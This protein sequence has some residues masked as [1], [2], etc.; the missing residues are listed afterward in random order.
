S[1]AATRH[2]RGLE[3]GP[4]GRRQAKREVWPHSLR[5]AS[6]RPLGGHQCPGV[7]AARPPAFRAAARLASKRG[8]KSAPEAISANKV[9]PTAL[10]VAASATLAGLCCWV[11]RV[12]RRSR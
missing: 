3:E 2:I 8:S 5:T 12:R 11:V 4:R 7:Q 10:A 9:R 6:G 1:L